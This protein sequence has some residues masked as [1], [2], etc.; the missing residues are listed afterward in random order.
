MGLYVL[1]ENEAELINMSFEHIL[2]FIIEKPKNVLSEDIQE[3][4]RENLLYHKLKL[5]SKGKADLGYI[6]QKLE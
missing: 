1:S 6:L 2:N 5:S 4:T 3:Q